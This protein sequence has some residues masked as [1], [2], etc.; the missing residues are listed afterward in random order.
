MSRITASSELK[1]SDLK[2]APEDRWIDDLLEFVNTANRQ[3]FAA[4]D[5]A[6]TTLEN[7]VDAAIVVDLV[8]GVQTPQ[9]NPLDVPI[10]GIFPMRCQGVNVDSTGKPTKGTYVLGMPRID[11]VPSNNGG[12]LIT[13]TYPTVGARGKV[14]LFFFGG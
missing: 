2:G 5:R 10:Q 11:W 3:V 1:R 6:I 9:Q 13:A 14:R 12:A 8:H 7:T 4:F